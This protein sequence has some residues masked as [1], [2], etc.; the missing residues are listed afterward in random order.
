MRIVFILIEI[1]RRNKEVK[2]CLKG[3]LGI[4]EDRIEPIPARRPQCTGRIHESRER[5]RNHL[6]GGILKGHLVHH[7][8]GRIV[9]I[10]VTLNATAESTHAL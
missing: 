5:H 8:R 7:V 4:V 3:L 1:T 6:V 2:W 10:L 9:E